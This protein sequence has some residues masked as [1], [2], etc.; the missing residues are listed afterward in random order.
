MPSYRIV[1]VL[2]EHGRWPDVLAGALPDPDRIPERIKL[3]EDC[4]IAQ[5]YLRLR[6]AGS[7]VEVARRPQAG[8]VNVVNGVAFGSRRLVPGAFFV[9]CRSDGTGGE[10]AQLVVVQNP[11][12]VTGPHCSVLPH[13]PQP[14]L[15]PRDPARGTRVERVVFKGDHLVNLVGEL[16]DDAFRAALAAMGC[17]WE[18]SG[19]SS[20][21]APVA[22]HDYRDADV[23][24]ALRDL[25]VGFADAKPASKLVNAWMAGV[26]ALLGPESAYRDLRRSPYDYLEVRSARE[27]LE[28][29]RW[30]REHPA[31]YLEIARNGL[32]RACE[33]SAEA[34]VRRWWAY[35]TGPVVAGA[36]AR[37][38]RRSGVGKRL[39][40]LRRVVRHRRAKARR[41][42][43]W[44]TTPSV[45]A[46][47]SSLVLPADA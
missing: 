37:F 33:F 17:A 45:L 15:R 13:W 29:V 14:G 46:G 36:F 6:R 25:T 40:A 2:A 19:K 32:S 3:N 44:R 31:V 16:R 39:D 22:W 5:T 7:P 20:G 21:G 18:V 8:A 34:L 41:T 47:P 42:R 10:L 27:V 43:R 11:R 35:L 12:D 4:W 9:A 26:P 23:A 28:A 1:F 24:V 30:L 38:E